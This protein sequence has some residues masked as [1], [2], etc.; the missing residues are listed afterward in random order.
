[1]TIKMAKRGVT[2]GALLNKSKFIGSFYDQLLITKYGETEMKII[3]EM[4]IRFSHLIET[5]LK[6]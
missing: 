5:G 2:T 1:M 6:C 4:I 3:I